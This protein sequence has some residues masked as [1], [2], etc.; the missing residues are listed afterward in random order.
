[1][2][3]KIIE[4][5]SKNF[6]E[7]VLQS[8]T[9]VLVDFWAPWCQP[10]LMMSPV[11]EE[12]AGELEGKVKIAKLNVESEENQQ[13]AIQYRIRSIPNMKVFKN[14]EVIKD[15]VGLRPKEGL[16]SELKAQL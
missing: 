1:M 15:F 3:S 7:E 4:L 10:C 14:G 8:K 11:L 5:S 13:L 6:S 16:E 9:P 12:L 2:M